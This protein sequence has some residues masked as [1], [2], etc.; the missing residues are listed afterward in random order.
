MTFRNCCGRHGSAAVLQ[1]APQLQGT[2]CMANESA[3]SILSV[4][5]P[6]HS[7]YLSVLRQAVASAALQLGF[8]E[9]AALQLAMAVDEAATNVIEHGCRT[10]HP[11]RI[12]L[13]LETGPEELVMH[14]HDNCRPFS[15][16]QRPI[17][18]LDEYFDSNRTKGL[19][20]LIISRFVDEV[21]HSYLADS[22]NTLSLVKH[23]P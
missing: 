23:L 8:D 14:V 21:R 17:P 4:T 19:G 12:S 15:P 18:S 2:A 11:A 9:K 22:G 3:N 16:L 7:A 5:V 10:T 6:E 13:E 1:H 20:L